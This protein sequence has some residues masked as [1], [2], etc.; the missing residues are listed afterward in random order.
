LLV[1]KKRFFRTSENAY[2]YW[3]VTTKYYGSSDSCILS[4]IVKT[5]DLRIT[6]S[7]ERSTVAV[8]LCVASVLNL[9]TAECLVSYASDNSWSVYYVKPSDVEY[10]PPHS[11]P[12]HILDYYVNNSNI[13]SN[14][15]FLFL[16]GLH[17]LQSTAEIRNVTNLAL[18]GMAGLTSKSYHR[19]WRCRF[20]LNTDLTSL[21]NL[22]ASNM[23]SS[24]SRA[25]SCGSE[26]Q[27]FTGIALSAVIVLK[28][29]L[30]S[31]TS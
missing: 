20:R 11:Q 22:S 4:Y 17:I 18:I 16:N 3:A 2:Y 28:L 27:D 8:V 25:M 6:M 30:N 24:S 12:C 9:L 1:K 7:S 13:S 21:V 15:T 5:K 29:M 10:C 31:H 26:N 14:S 19:E 23:G